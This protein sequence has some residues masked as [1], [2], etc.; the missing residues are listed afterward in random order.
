M[1]STRVDAAVEL[2][3]ANARIG[4]WEPLMEPCELQLATQLNRYTSELSCEISTSTPLNFNLT[5]ALVEQ[6]PPVHALHAPPRRPWPA[7]RAP[8]RPAAAL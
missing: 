7:P 5:A 1:H 8:P 6:V 2:A 3:Y 4:A